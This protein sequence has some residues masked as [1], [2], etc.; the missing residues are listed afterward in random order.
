MK[1]L[2]LVRTFFA[3]DAAITDIAWGQKPD[4]R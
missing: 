2:R 1:A 3:H 4:P